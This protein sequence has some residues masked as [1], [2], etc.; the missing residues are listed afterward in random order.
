MDHGE[1]CRYARGFAT[2]RVS[3]RVSV[4]PCEENAEVSTSVIPRTH[5]KR[6]ENLQ[7]EELFNFN[8]D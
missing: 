2:K 7:N 4:S 5:G 8:V 1:K 3:L 6:G